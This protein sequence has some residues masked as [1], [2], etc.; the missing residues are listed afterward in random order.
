MGCR[1]AQHNGPDV[2]SANQIWSAR[3]RSPGEPGRLATCRAGSALPADCVPLGPPADELACVWGRAGAIWRANRWRSGQV[4]VADVNRSP[5]GRPFIRRAPLIWRD[6]LAECKQNRFVL[7]QR[8]AGGPLAGR[9]RFMGP[10]DSTGCHQT[11]LFINRHANEPRPA[12]DR[13]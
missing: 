12:P 13:T 1:P 10:G 9:R 6:H 5:N 8:D 3:K 7:A 4:K 2:D 11:R